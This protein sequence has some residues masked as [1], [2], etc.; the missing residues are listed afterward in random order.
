[1]LVYPPKH[2]HP[3]ETMEVTLPC[4]ALLGTRRAAQLE[5]AIEEDT[6]LPCP[7]RLGEECPLIAGLVL[8]PKPV[9]AAP[10]RAS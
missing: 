3:G 5:A 9:A 10:P 8:T 7:C 6:G 1:M 2:G 4:V